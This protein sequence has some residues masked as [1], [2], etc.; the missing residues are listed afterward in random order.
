VTRLPLEIRQA[1]KTIQDDS[2]LDIL[3]MLSENGEMAFSDIQQKMHMTSGNLTYHLQPLRDS[4]LVEN[5]FKKVANVDN[6]S[7]YRATEFGE[8]LVDSLFKVLIPGP[9]LK[10]YRRTHEREITIKDTWIDEVKFTYP[11]PR[12]KTAE[13]YNQNTEEITINDN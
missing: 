12:Q 11:Q 3:L 4:A 1:L 13:E 9:I 7:F 5:F 6:H 2:R 8:R 10:E